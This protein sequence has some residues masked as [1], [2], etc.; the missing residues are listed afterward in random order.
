MES[1]YVVAPIRLLRE[2]NYVYT[3]SQNLQIFGCQNQRRLVTNNAITDCPKA[4]G[5]SLPSEG[6]QIIFF[7]EAAGCAKDLVWRQD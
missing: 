5:L 2:V 7:V 1:Q 4:T 3:L 6:V